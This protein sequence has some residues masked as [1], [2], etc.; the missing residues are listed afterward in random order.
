MPRDIKIFTVST[1]I[2]ALLGLHYVFIEIRNNVI[3]TET[4]IPLPTITAF[5]LNPKY[6]KCFFVSQC[7]DVLL[8]SKATKQMVKALAAQTGLLVDWWVF[9][10][11]L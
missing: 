6:L 11:W 3:P 5:I 9:H 8:T 2:L 7:K 10:L 1:L 4:G